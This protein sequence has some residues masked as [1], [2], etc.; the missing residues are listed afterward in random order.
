MSLENAHL[1]RN[2]RRV[3]RQDIST[4]KVLIVDDKLDNL[5]LAEA[6]VRFHGAQIRTAHNGKQGLEVLKNFLPTLILLDLSM[7]EMDGWEMFD[8]LKNKPETATIPVIALTAHAMAGDKERVLET[9][10]T[11]Y[12]PKPFSVATFVADIEAILT[13]AAT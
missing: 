5:A 10:F 12:I 9:G 4:W 7:P 2:Q 3:T 1:S 8:I 13:N 6:A 11:G